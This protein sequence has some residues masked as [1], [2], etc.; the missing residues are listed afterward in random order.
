MS[1]RERSH[2]YIRLDGD[3]IPGWNLL[4]YRMRKRAIGWL[5]AFFTYLS[6]FI[7]LAPL[8]WMF[9]TGFRTE[10]QVFAL[11]SPLLPN[12]V[13]FEH[14]ETIVRNTSYVRWY[15]NTLIF[16]GGVVFLTTSTATLAG[17]GLTRINIPHKRLFAR[18]ILFGYM[19]PAILLAIPMF[20]F[21]RQLGWVNSMW[22][23]I[24]AQTATALPFSI[25]MMWK[26]FQTVPIS[27]EES[28]QMA[29]ASRFQAFY[30]IALPM[31]KP[32]MIAIA[33][34]SYAVAWNSFTIPQIIMT[35]NENWVLS[36]G[37]FSFIVQNRVLWG[38]L[39][40][41]SSLAVIPSFLFVYFLQKY[42][43]RGFRAG[44]V[45]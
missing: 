7:I 12:P 4:S 32:G 31:A 17:Y 34:F 8:A 28:A 15:V 39:M 25:W 33:V 2:V 13:S 24:L 3:S 40:A 22:G 43:L 35:S 1:L 30:E 11:P 18:V 37:L 23:L 6:V 29:G 10:A 44:G 42:L 41:A 20:I 45:G 26:F 38:Q 36:I 16:A 5:L 14:L 19:F 21:W 27:L 9:S